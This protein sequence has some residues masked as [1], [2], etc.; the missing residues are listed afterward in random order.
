MLVVVPTYKRLDCLRLSLLSVF[1]NE[2]PSHEPCRL[3]LSN[4]Y[5]PHRQDVEEIVSTLS[6]HPNF[7]KWE[8]IFNHQL[9]TVPAV[10]NWYQT[11]LDFAKE[12]EM[13]V[14]HG[15]DD[16]LTPWSLA[17]RQS[18][19]DKHQAD[20]LLTGVC[21][22]LTFVSST[23]IHYRGGW[24]RRNRNEQGVVLSF[25]TFEDF[26]NVFIGSHTYRNTVHFRAAIEKARAWTE[27]Q[28][29]VDY[30]TRNLMFPYYLLLAIQLTPAKVI[31]SH[32][33]G[34][35]RGTSLEE[36][37]N[38][39]FNNSY[40]WNSGVL[41]MLMME[42]VNHQELKDKPIAKTRAILE[43]EAANW[44]L[45]LFLDKRLSL[46]F[47][48]ELLT[49]VSLRIKARNYWFGAKVILRQY[50]GLKALSVRWDVSRGKNIYTPAALLHRMMSHSNYA[51][52]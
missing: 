1:N 5:P 30:H 29:W 3:V 20:F 44:Y 52:K 40:G 7:R 45:T 11:I 18:L 36:K 49:R 42:L 6:G 33:H 23:S 48:N 28:T 4:N 2:L 35:I 38:A 15:D 25:A 31:G 51:L 13:V 9:Q 37:V 16:L 50:L 10:D 26:G 46:L 32:W 43:N 27:T 12:G 17:D 24:P 41:L 8:I 22:G 39:P 34:C 21:S 19:A 47:R 14:L